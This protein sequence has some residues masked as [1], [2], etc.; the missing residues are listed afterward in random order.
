MPDITLIHPKSPFLITDAVFPPLGIMY[1]ASHLKWEGYDVQCLD[2]GIGHKPEEAKSDLIGISFTTSQRGEAYKLVKHYKSIWG[3][4]PFLIAGGPHATHKPMECL[5]NGFDLVIKN[6]A[7]FHLPSVM[8]TLLETPHFM[9]NSVFTPLPIGDLDAMPYPDRDALPIKD[10]K[11]YIDGE[12]ATTIMTSR[13]CPFSC[14]FCAKLP[15]EFRQQ[16]GLRTLSEILYL[17]DKYGYKAFMIFDDVFV[18]DRKRL[19]EI[20]SRLKDA[21]LIF[22]CFGRSNLLTVEAC[23][24]LKDMGTVEV[25]IGIESG[26]TKILTRNM[27][28]TTTELNS[29]AIENLRNV[30]IRSKAFIIVGLPGET[31]ETVEETRSWLR[32]NKPDDVDVSIFQPL[33]GSAIFDEPHK[34]GIKFDY[35]SSPSWYKGKPGEYKTTVETEGLSS[36]RITYLRDELEHE[37]K[38][39]ENLK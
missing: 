31:E 3:F 14:S 22:R 24:M 5:R 35:E 34:W 2:M 10:Y 13:G 15:N 33:P 20:S 36:E 11:Y 37:F 28:R 16:S 7:D 38:R 4:K 1:L 32:E 18:A 17:N 21:G 23:T 27:K 8:P 12:L 19:Y 9:K 29:M 30:G 6:E 39:K 26:S 25:G